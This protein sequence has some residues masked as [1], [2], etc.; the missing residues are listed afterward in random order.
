MT[1]TVKNVDGVCELGECCIPV[2][3]LI[4]GELYVGT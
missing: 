1:V 4:G 3:F 2:D